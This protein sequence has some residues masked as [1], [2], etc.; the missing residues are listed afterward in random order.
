MSSE[1]LRAL[2]METGGTTIKCVF[3]SKL[4]E[5][6]FTTSKDNVYVDDRNDTLIITN[7]LADISEFETEI[8]LENKY[9]QEIG[10]EYIEI[11]IYDG[12]SSK[13]FL[14]VL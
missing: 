12:V 11:E 13:L 8:N 14:T 5:I 6:L 3:Y 2:L 7:D 4:G 1:D 10:D 9:I